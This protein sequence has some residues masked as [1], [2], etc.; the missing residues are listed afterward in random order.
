MSGSDTM[1]IVNYL[2][3]VTSVKGLLFFEAEYLDLIV[4]ILENLEL[5]L[6]VQ[7]VHAFTSINF[8]HSHEVFYSLFISSN[9]EYIIDNWDHIDSERTLIFCD[10]KCE[11]NPKKQLESIK[12]INKSN[13]WAIL[14]GP[15]GGFS[16]KEREKINSIKNLSIISLG[17][18]ILRSDTAIVSSLTL[19][20]STMGDWV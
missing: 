14:I 16:D 4:L 6:V 5:F 7:Q 8:K 17:P 18:R 13:K 10:E 9:L 19:F 2:L 1:A 3:D 20:H 15:E 11:N 12:S